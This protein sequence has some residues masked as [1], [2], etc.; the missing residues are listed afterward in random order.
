[1]GRVTESVILIPLVVCFLP[2]KVTAI[3]ILAYS[4]F[5]ATKW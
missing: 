2:F 1:M 4:L 3:I 5:R